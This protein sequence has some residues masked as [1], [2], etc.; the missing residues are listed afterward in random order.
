MACVVSTI[1]L[2]FCGFCDPIAGEPDLW[3]FPKKSLSELDTP[4]KMAGR[5]HEK[6][7]VFQVPESFFSKTRETQP[8]SGCRRFQS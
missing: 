3:S 4:L 2:C 1:L 6:P 7:Y 5:N 8:R